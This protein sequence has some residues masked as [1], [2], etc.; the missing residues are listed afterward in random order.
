MMHIIEWI[1]DLTDE[2]LEYLSK[3]WDGYFRV[4]RTTTVRKV[5]E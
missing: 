5:K 2:E 3:E 4:I 1:Y